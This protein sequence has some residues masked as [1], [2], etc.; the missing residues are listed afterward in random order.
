VAPSSWQ[1]ANPSD[2]VYE[3]LP[4]DIHTLIIACSATWYQSRPP[5]IYI[6]IDITL[7][8]SEY[9]ILYC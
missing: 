5:D 6:G 2:Y 4:N 7:V 8:L 9:D 3:K 1:W